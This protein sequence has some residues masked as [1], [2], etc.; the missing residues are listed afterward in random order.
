MVILMYDNENFEFI[1]SQLKSDL[2]GSPFYIF[3]E[4][5]G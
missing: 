1:V 2:E 5:N 4:E 3:V